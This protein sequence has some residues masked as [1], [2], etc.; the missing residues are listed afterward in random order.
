DAP[1][2][3]MDPATPAQRSADQV[4]PVRFKVR[5]KALSFP[6][7]KAVSPHFAVQLMRDSS[8][9]AVDADHDG[10]PDVWPRVFLVRLDASDPSG[11]TQYRLPDLKTT[12]TQVIPAA[13]D[14]TPFIT[15]LQP[16]TN[17]NAP[18][19]LTDRV[20]VVVRPTL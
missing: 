6:A 14:P 15:A 1:A 12:V 3:G 10:L 2:F 4:T 16:Q 20:T 18:P 5:A 11:L 19:V 7:G 8:G 13:I 9:A 17:G